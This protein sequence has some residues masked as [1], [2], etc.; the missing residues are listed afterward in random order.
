MAVFRGQS[1]IF[2]LKLKNCIIKCKRQFAYKLHQNLDSFIN[3]LISNVNVIIKY[4][5]KKSM[6]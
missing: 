5:Y 4:Q 2:V 6:A 1:A 3:T